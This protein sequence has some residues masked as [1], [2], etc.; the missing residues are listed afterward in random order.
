MIALLLGLLLTFTSSQ[1]EI[2]TADGT[3]IVNKKVEVKIFTNK[4]CF[5]N[6]CY[7]TLSYD[8]GLKLY[9]I[10]NGNIQIRESRIVFRNEI[11]TRIYHKEKVF[12]DKK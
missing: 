1:H 3:K 10:Y 12:N 6:D 8:E 11:D 2:I 5:N 4:I 9:T 7:Y